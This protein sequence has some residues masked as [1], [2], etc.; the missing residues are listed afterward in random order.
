[1]KAKEKVTGKAV[2]LRDNK[3]EAGVEKGEHEKD[4]LMQKKIWD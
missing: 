3:N 4:E 2:N 1:M